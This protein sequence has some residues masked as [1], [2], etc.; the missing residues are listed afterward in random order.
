MFFDDIADTLLK[1]DFVANVEPDLTIDGYQRDVTR[2][3]YA[4][5]TW[6]LD[7]VSAN[8][9]E[10]I[11]SIQAPLVYTSTCTFELHGKDLTQPERAISALCDLQDAIAGLMFLLSPEGTM[12]VTA[13]SDDLRRIT[14]SYGGKDRMVLTV[15]CRIKPPAAVIARGDLD[16]FM[17][18]QEQAGNAMKLWR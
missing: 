12:V 5:R 4:C 13:D 6:V 7:Q 10:A 1:H 14:F 3:V 8:S 11:V 18:L 9:I 2:H 15:K 17:R 16:E